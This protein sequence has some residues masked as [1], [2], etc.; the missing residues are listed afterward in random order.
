MT[1]AGCRR[2]PVKGDSD[3]APSLRH[4][5]CGWPAA[6]GTGEEAA[7]STGLAA[8][9]PSLVCRRATSRSWSTTHAAM[10]TISSPTRARGSSGS[11]SRN[12]VYPAV[13][14]I[15]LPLESAAQGL[16]LSAHFPAGPTV[17]V[18]L[19]SPLRRGY[20]R[21]Q[22]FPVFLPELD[23][24]NNSRNTWYTLSPLITTRR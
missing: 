24:G 16:R 7:A 23:A 19:P 20:L 15:R 8:A 17:T 14:S 10:L 21:G 18:R 3:S 4:P 9:S 13:S 6:P 11:G 1:L 22:G 5:S 2:R 12:R